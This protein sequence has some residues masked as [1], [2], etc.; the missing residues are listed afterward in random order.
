MTLPARWIT[1]AVFKLTEG[2]VQGENQADVQLWLNRG[3]Q[4]VQCGPCVLCFPGWSPQLPWEGHGWTRRN[5][6]PAQDPT[7][8]S[9]S[10]HTKGIRWYPSRLWAETAWTPE[11]AAGDKSLLTFWGGSLLKYFGQDKSAWG[12]A[13]HFHHVLCVSR[14][15]GLRNPCSSLLEI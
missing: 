8:S 3:L 13:P 12:H 7:A 2:A 15:C 6:P 9:S 10:G 11:N 1:T 14:E 5:V 4:R